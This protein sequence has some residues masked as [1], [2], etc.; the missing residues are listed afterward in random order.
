MNN[1]CQKRTFE[2]GMKKRHSGMKAAGGRGA[3]ESMHQA[4]FE[5]LESRTM[6]SVSAPS[7]L[8]AVAAGSTSVQ[9]NWQ[10]NDLAATGYY[11]L[12]STDGTHFANIAKISSPSATT[13][14]DKTALSGRNY[15]YEVEAFSGATV[16]A[17]ATMATVGTPLTGPTGL[18][19]KT[20]TPTSVQLTW[21]DHDTT[22]VGYQILRSTNG[23]SFTQIA[24]VAGAK[25][26]T[27]TDKTAA[28]DTAYAYQVRAYYGGG[29]S[30]VA[31]SASVR[32]AL[33]A[34]SSMTATAEDFTT[35]QL[36]WSDND[37]SAAGYYL[38]RS[39][40]GKTFSVFATVNDGGA[41]SYQDSGAVSGHTY[42]YEVQAFDG[43]AA[44][45][46]TKMAAASTPLAA[47]SGLSATVMSPTSVQLSWTNND[48]STLGYIILRSSDGVHFSQIAK[49][50]TPAV[51]TYLDKAATSAHT[52]QYK[53]EAVAGTIVS[54][55]TDAATASTPLAPPASLTAAAS[56]PTSVVLTWQDKET[57]AL[58]YYVLRATDGV[59]FTLL[60]TVSGPKATT[61]TDTSVSSNS[62]YSYKVEC[63]TGNNTSTASNSASVTTPL[64]APSG[65][66]AAAQGFTSMALGWTDNDSAATGY[67]VL[68]STDGTHWTQIA[69]LN[70]AT[71]HG[72]TD[73]GLADGHA[74]DYEV[75]AYNGSVTSAFAKAMS[76]TTPLAAPSGLTTTV[77]GPTSVT[78]HWTDNDS[79]ATGYTI[80]RST[81]GVN[82]TLLAKV[83][84]VA[85]NS[86][87]DAAATSGHALSY[88]VE[89]TSAA[90]ISTP[91]D[92]AHATTPL[93]AP[94]SLTVSMLGSYVQLK[95]TNKDA[96]TTGYNIL[97]S[98]DGVTYTSIAT[99]S[100]ASTATYTD[101]TVSA[102]ATYRYE[103]QA[104]N[105][106]ANSAVSN[107]GTITTPLG[108][109]GGVAITMRFG[110]ELIIT[111]SGADDSISILQSGSTLTIDADG[112]TF[113]DA[114]PAA[115]VFVYTRG[116]ADSVNVD[117]SVTSEVTIDSIDNS[118][119]VITSGGSNVGIWADSTDSF[120]G[121]GTLH[122]VT[123]FLGGTSKALNQALANPKDSGSLVTENLSLWGTGPVM[124]DINQGE[125]GD[126]YFLSSLAAFANVK[127]QM[128]QQSAVDLGDGTF[129][130]QFFKNG[131]AQYVRVNDQFP[132]GPFA[133][134]DYAHM[135][136]NGTIWGM[137]L[138]K[139][140]CYFRTGANTYN[141]I[142]SGWMGEVYS[143]F[144]ISSTNFFPSNYSESA[145]F[146]MVSSALAS[147]KAVTLG[148]SGSPPNL[149]E[150]HAY[151]LVS[152]TQDGN[153]VTQYVVRNPW[154]TQGDALEN[155]GGYATLTFA[156]MV[157]NFTDGCAAA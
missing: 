10:D 74:Y 149:V 103:I 6:M 126:C 121:T 22:A 35:V 84:G 139:A 71:A 94:A 45:A 18:V 123:T 108:G 92:A 131:S 65:L 60:A 66:T 88:K 100:G 63:F 129:A 77:N 142:N 46:A 154:G 38:L 118:M 1:V 9:L 82:F 24:Q 19:A 5:A 110:D 97:R 137:V 83:T 127:P 11:V 147:N 54:A 152:C 87:T 93:V 21:A 78:L 43:G 157:A 72:F 28:S 23:G 112:Q 146:S 7:D 117:V 42:D 134:L 69:N 104:T 81:D 51:T 49:L 26:V 70:S 136:S 102:G 138:E 30:P 122:S 2:L 86:Y 29:T 115:G 68:R 109:S 85:T 114:V 31:T 13:Y 14:L 125:V 48:S 27:Y 12:R 4:A 79:A 90:A 95:W 20:L 52:F 53:V 128:L 67:N 73:S 107:V 105:T 33:I 133:G 106:A 58:G 116:G 80:L 44:S 47:P 89:A 96:S 39:T 61:Y 144:N 141:S 64:A 132:A 17:P 155:S 34:P 151:T 145:F 76:A 50:T 16:S 153:G 55:A 143:D 148:T 59:N 57:T 156:Q 135:G 75:Q 32:T 130:V 56:G 8:A 140:F 36:N 62:A 3:R 25:V 101:T 113:Q 99:V 40:N 111:A 91:T 15:N 120:S 41:T 98:S 150:D 124:G 119:D 37:A